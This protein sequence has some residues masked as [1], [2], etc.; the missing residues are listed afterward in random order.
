MPRRTCEKWR[1]PQI[2]EFYKCYSS[3]FL[4]LILWWNIWIPIRKINFLSQLLGALIGSGR[5]KIRGGNVFSVII[6][7][8]LESI[9]PSQAGLHQW[10]GSRNQKEKGKKR[11]LSPAEVNFWRSSEFQAGYD[12]LRPVAEAITDVL[13]PSRVLPFSSTDIDLRGLLQILLIVSI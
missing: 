13:L 12:W 10:V 1:L 7:F 4:G 3:W 8:S 5:K 2:L 11:P 6:S 9:S